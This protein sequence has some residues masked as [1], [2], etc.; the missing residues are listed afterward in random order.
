[1]STR[2]GL[3]RGRRDYINGYIAGLG[4][5]HG[6]VCRLHEFVTHQM[7]LAE[8]MRGLEAAGADEQAH[9]PAQIQEEA[10]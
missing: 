3:P 7:H 6:C 2:T 5:R 8:A 1:M 9:S 10:A 4:R